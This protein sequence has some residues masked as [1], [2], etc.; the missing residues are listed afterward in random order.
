VL[1][2]PTPTSTSQPEKFYICQNV[3]RVSTDGEVCI[4]ISTNEFPG[5]L[6]LKIYNSAGEHIKDLYKTYLTAPLAPTTINWDGRNK[7]GQKVA[8]GVYLL[9]L[10]KPYGRLMGRLVV[11]Q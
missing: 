6:Q 7:Y 3:F 5:P 11:I 8:S 4:T 1:T 9:Y 2:S 10:I